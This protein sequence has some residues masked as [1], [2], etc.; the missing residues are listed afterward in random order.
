MLKIVVV[1]TEGLCNRLRVVFS[2][3]MKAKSEGRPLVVIWKPSAEC[4]GFF[5][6]YFEPLPNTRFLTRNT[7]PRL[8]VAYKG[9]Q[10]HPSF[11]PYESFIYEGLLLTTAMEKRVQALVDRLGGEDGFIS[12][13]V[14]RTDH[15]A[16]AMAQGMLTPL[17]AFIRFIDSHPTKKAYLATDNHETQAVF[18]RRYGPH[19]LLSCTTIPVSD[20][21]RKTSLEDAV[22]DIFVAS[23]ASHFMGSGYSSFSS[24]IEHLYTRRKRLLTEDRETETIRELQSLDP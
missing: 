23:R 22:V 3:Y 4:N 21:L 12:L 2:Y 8:P 9:Y 24:L 1:P 15:T 20:A 16:L 5:L 7:D 13:H 11:S 10:W 17:E 6:D 19:R 18:A 14:R